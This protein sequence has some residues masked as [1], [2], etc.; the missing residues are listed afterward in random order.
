[1]HTDHKFLRSV[2]EA[3]PSIDNRLCSTSQKRFEYVSKSFWKRVNKNS[4]TWWWYVL[5]T[6]WRDLCKTSWRHL[7]NVLKMSWRRMTKTIILVLIKTSSEDVWVRRIYLSWSRHLE[8]VLKTSSEDEDEGRLHQDECLL[9]GLSNNL[10]HEMQI[11]DRK[12]H[13]K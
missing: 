13:F 5:K 8:D 11:A 1:M 4:L 9:G 7:E 10:V 2:T 6:S 12:F 3:N